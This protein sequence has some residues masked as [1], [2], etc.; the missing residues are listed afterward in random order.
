[1][2][3]GVKGTVNEAMRVVKSSRL[4][5]DGTEEAMRGACNGAKK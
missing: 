3:E 4:D 1:M 2:R 5:N